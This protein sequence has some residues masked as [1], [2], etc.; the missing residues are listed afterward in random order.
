MDGVGDTTTDL[1]W[2]F[3]PKLLVTAHG[4]YAVTGSPSI[5]CRARTSARGVIRNH[6]A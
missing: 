3:L 6:K 5:D 4:Y 1:E 2:V